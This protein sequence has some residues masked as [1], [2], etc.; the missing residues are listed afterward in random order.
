MRDKK[1]S[2]AVIFTCYN[3]AEKTR[4]CIRSLQSQTSH[5][6]TD[7]DYY[8]CDDGSTDDTCDMIKALLPHARIV[9]GDGKLFWVRGMHRAMQE[10]VRSY[11][12]F[13]LMVNDD[14]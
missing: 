1:V 7:L 11:H 3:R 6:L 9:K 5:Y 2:I 13:Y 10:A 8:I 4:A 12:D 14:V